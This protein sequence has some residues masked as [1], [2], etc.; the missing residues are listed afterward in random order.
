MLFRELVEFMYKFLISS[1]SI[2]SGTLAIIMTP[3]GIE[4]TAN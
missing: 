2:F 1:V 4:P 3:V